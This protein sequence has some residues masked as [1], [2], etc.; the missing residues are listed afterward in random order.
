MSLVSMVFGQNFI[1]IVSDS[2]A[3]DETGKTISTNY[4]KFKVIDNN[5]VIAGAGSSV[6]FNTLFSDIEKGL[7]KYGP[8]EVL[9]KIAQEISSQQ[10]TE[11]TP[12]ITVMACYHNFDGIHAIMQ[13][14]NEPVSKII[15]PFGQKYYYF[16]TGP[17]EFSEQELR[18]KFEMYLNKLQI[19]TPSEIRKCQIKL[20][21][22]VA[23][24]C[25]EKVNRHINK[26]LKEY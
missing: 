1:S 12:Y 6:L 8:D 13:H 20:N 19:S 15:K 9:N 10:S 4:K 17:E 5:F 24:R 16:I 7:L 25:P 18:N 26:Y 23:N 3:T 14:N 21:N 2:L 11:S 22:F